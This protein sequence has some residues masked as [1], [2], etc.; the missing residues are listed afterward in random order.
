MTETLM[1]AADRWRPL[2]ELLGA[3]LERITG[4]LPGCLGAGLTVGRGGRPPQVLA[5]AGVAAGL[6][7]VSL[8]HGGPVAVAAATGEPVTTDDLF[9]DGRWPGLSGAVAGPELAAI[10]GAAALP[11]LWEDTSA[12][13]LSAVFDRPLDAGVL[14]V[15]RRYEKLTETTLVVAEAATAGDP[16]QTLDLLA[17]RAAIEQAKGV[18]MAVRRC[19]PDEAWQTLRRGSQEFNVKVREL[20]VALVEHVGGGHA[21]DGAREIR[22][23]AP[24]RHAAERLW[25]AFTAE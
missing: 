21:P 13:V 16:D 17:S 25:S 7:P 14:S 1:N 10:R 23:G 24:A 8:A 12:F 11:G 5:A 15:L 9:A 4:E 22:P 18:V 20:A 3:L 2:T 6:L 19:A